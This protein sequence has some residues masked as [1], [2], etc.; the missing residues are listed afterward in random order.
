MGT[1][2]AAARAFDGRRR[3]PAAPRSPQAAR[4]VENLLAVPNAVGI[5]PVLGTMQ[6]RLGNKVASATVQRMNQDSETKASGGGTSIRKKVTHAL[7]RASTNINVVDTF[8][9]RG[10]APADSGMGWEA[11]R[12]GDAHLS[13]Q[14]DMSGTA[15][16]AE[17]GLADGLATVGNIIDARRAYK[18]KKQHPD[19]PASHAPRKTFKAKMLDT[20]LNAV[21]TSTD[22]IAAARNGLAADGIVTAPGVAEGGGAGFGVFTAVSSARAARRAART[23]RTYRAIKKVEAPAPVGDDELA[24]LRG[25]KRHSNWALAEAY[26]AVERAHQGGDEGYADR[27]VDSLDQVTDAFGAID[28]AAEDLKRAQDTNA[29]NTTRSYALGKQRTKALKLG[30]SAVGESTRTAGTA[31]GIAAVTTGALASNPA[32]WALAATAAGLLVSINMYKTVRAGVKRYDGARHP[33]RWSEPTEE[34]GTSSAEPASRGDALKEALKFWKKVENGQRQ[35]MAR[36]IYGLA[37]GPEVPAGKDT[38]RE[39]R[40]S[41]RE[42]LIALK[43]G[44]AKMRMTEEEWAQSLNNPDDAE[45][46]LKEIANQLSSG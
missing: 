46:W 7:D 30:I 32:G 11:G 37:A 36:T 42:L 18:E 31:V 19:G 21:S 17:M 29:L 27:L 13:S 39:L 1:A 43:A 28:K 6:A 38:T 20:I 2:A 45:R 14:V 15:A 35:A 22:I 5:V 8:V 10:Q 4:G 16:N 25:A 23:G 41:A 34:G 9:L 26:V 24:E 3:Q 12:T 33:D 40:A 44:P